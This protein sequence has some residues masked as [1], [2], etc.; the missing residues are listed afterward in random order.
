MVSKKS[1][2]EGGCAGMMGSLPVTTSI[3]NVEKYSG[4]AAHAKTKHGH[5]FGMPVRVSH[6]GAGSVSV[7]SLLLGGVSFLVIVVG[8]VLVEAHVAGGFAHHAEA[9][10]AVLL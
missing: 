8:T 6:R 3:A 10:A 1:S 5:P 2:G 4:R 7:R 9:G